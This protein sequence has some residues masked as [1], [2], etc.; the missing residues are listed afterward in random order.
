VEAYAAQ[1]HSSIELNVHDD[2]NI[3][4]EISVENKQTVGNLIQMAIQTTCQYKSMHY[5]NVNR[6]VKGIKDSKGLTIQR[7]QK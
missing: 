4:V 1:Q 3:V 2:C 5:G 6:N 7:T